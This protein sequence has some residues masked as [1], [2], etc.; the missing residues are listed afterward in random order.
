M[1]KSFYRSTFNIETDNFELFFE[2]QLAT[3]TE[4]GK[5][6]I[7]KDL[8]KIFRHDGTL[9]HGY[10]RKLDYN[11]KLWILWRCLKKRVWIVVEDEDGGIDVEGFVNL[12]EA[13]KRR[14]FGSKKAEGLTTQATFVTGNRDLCDMFNYLRQLS[15]S[16]AYNYLNKYKNFK[17]TKTGQQVREMN[18]IAKFIRHYEG[19]KKKW[20]QERNVSMPEWYVLLF[21]YDKEYALGSEI[22]RVAFNRAYQSSVKKIKL[23]FRSLQARGLILKHGLNSGARMQITPMGRDLVNSILA[24][25]ILNC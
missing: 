4:A 9:H 16:P 2:K 1:L 20:N 14:D 22:Y 6:A 7:P 5:E 23:A 12:R 21:L 18:Y 3:I 24:T 10:I 11:T 17:S 15:A 25:Y 8:V 19:Y 13:I